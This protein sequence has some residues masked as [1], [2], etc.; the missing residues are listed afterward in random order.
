M[1]KLKMQI[2]KVLN[3]MYEKSLEDLL[4]CNCFRCKEKLTDEDIKEL[5]KKIKDKNKRNKKSR[6]PLKSYTFFTFYMDVL[7]KALYNKYIINS[8]LKGV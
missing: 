6:K 5:L 2:K 1:G 7:K 3:R 4:I 8:I